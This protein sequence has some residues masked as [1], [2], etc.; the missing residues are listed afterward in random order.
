M[1]SIMTNEEWVGRDELKETVDEL[2][3]PP[4]AQHE[5]LGLVVGLQVGDRSEVYGYGALDET[6]FIVPN[7]KTL[8]EI[9]SITKV[10][11]RLLLVTMVEEGLVSLDE[12]LRSLLPE[13]PDLPQNITLL[14]LATSRLPGLP[15]N[16]FETPDYNPRNPYGHLTPAQLYAYLATSRNGTGGAQS[17]TYYPADLGAA[18]LGDVLGRKLGL[19]YEQA[20][21]QRICDP[22]GLLD[23]RSKLTAK[24]QERLAPPHTPT[25]E[26]TLNWDLPRLS[27]A[28]GLRSTAQDLLI[29][30]E[31]SLRNGPFGWQASWPKKPGIGWQVSWPKEPGKAL[32][33]QNGATGGYRTF[34]GFRQA[35]QRG[36]VVLSNYGPSAKIGIDQI[37]ITLLDRLSFG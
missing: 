23:T 33:W 27:G 2:I 21:V 13:W 36:V 34:A 16:L 24:Q 19:S 14:G 31:H 3:S 32:Y 30:I 4:L 5:R 12:P 28:A 10:F 37:G 15:L 29:L 11:T 6:R 17:G 35:S 20:V 18:V 1:S 26:P 9:G 7:E 25:G 8:F 22:I